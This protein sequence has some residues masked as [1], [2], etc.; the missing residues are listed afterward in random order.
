MKRETKRAYLSRMRMLAWEEIEKVFGEA[1]CVQVTC[2]EDRATACCVWPDGIREYMEVEYAELE[3]RDSQH[4]RAV[5][6]IRRTV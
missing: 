4:W 1:V 6:E 3:Y 5:Q 2:G